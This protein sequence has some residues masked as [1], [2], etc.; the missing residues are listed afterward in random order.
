MLLRASE[1]FPP[2][3]RGGAVS[4]GNFD[5]VHRGHLR[6]LER[7]VAQ[8]RQLDNRAVVFT[9]DPSPASV[10]SPETAPLPLCWTERKAEL[11][12][13]LGVEV[14]WAFPTSRDFLQMEAKDFFWRFVVGQLEAKVLVEGSNFS[15]GRNR[16]AQIAHLHAWCTE[17]GIRLEVV[18]PLQVDNRTVSSSWIRQLLREGQVEKAAELLGRPYRIRGQ[19]IPGAGRGRQLGYPTANLQ[20]D[21]LLLPADGIYAGRAWLA[22]QAWPAAISLGPNPTFGQTEQKIEA[23]LI[24]FKGNLYHQVLELEFLA[25]LRPVRRFPEVGA[26]VAQMAQDVSATK[27]IVAQIQPQ[28]TGS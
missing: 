23:F 15:F 5:G 7:L 16:Q 11:M 18:P 4:I 1:N 13:Q 24:H 2:D 21:R 25:R 17:A 3:L 20:A 8:A 28:E 27:Q 6:L 12:N 10:L 19:V 9:F 22:G 14:V 26:L